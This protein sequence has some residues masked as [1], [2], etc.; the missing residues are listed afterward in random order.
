MKNVN[1]FFNFGGGVICSLIVMISLQVLFSFKLSAQ[2]PC[3]CDTPFTPDF[4]W[5][6]ESSS[7]VG[8]NFTGVNILISGTFLV[9]A[10]TTFSNCQIRL[11]ADADIS[12]SEGITLNVLS[13]HLWACT[14]TMWLGIISLNTQPIINTGTAINIFNSHIQDA[15]IAVLS[16]G[17]TKINIT[18]SLFENNLYGIQVQ[19]N[20]SPQPN[21]VVLANTF[22]S[23][24][25]VATHPGFPTGAQLINPWTNNPTINQRSYMGIYFKNNLANLQVGI[26]SPNTFNALEIG[27]GILASNVSV[28]NNV[29]KDIDLT[30]GANP[31]NET[32]AVLFDGWGFTPTTSVVNENNFT[33]CNRA[34][35][36]KTNN[37]NLNVSTNT[38]NASN[39]YL[40]NAS[41]DVWGIYVENNS[42]A[43]INIC[44]NTIENVGLAVGLILCSLSDVDVCSNRISNNSQA[45]NT[46]WGVL[47]INGI[48][49]TGFHEIQNN[50]LDNVQ[51]GIYA[52]SLNNPRIHN[53]EVFLHPLLV[54]NNPE[55]GMRT[56]ATLIP[57]IFNNMVS[58]TGTNQLLYA[59]DRITGIYNEGNDNALVFCNINNNCLWS[60]CGSMDNQTTP[61][62]GNALNNHRV[63]VAL[64]NG[65]V[66]GGQGSANFTNDN[67]WV[68]YC[69]NDTRTYGNSPIGGP[70]LTYGNLSPFMV[71]NIAPYN[72]I[73][74]TNELACFPITFSPTIPANPPLNENCTDIGVQ[75]NIGHGLVLIANGEKT[76]P[77]G[78]EAEHRHWDEV[79][80]YS[81]LYDNLDT[82]EK[83]AELD[84]FYAEI[85]KTPHGQLVAIERQLATALINNEQEKDS[86]PN[87]DGAWLSL[88]GDLATITPK[89]LQDEYQKTV[90]T[91][92]V[93]ANLGFKYSYTKQDADDITKIANTCPIRG[94]RTVYKA[95]AVYN[96]LFNLQ[97]IFDEN[98]D[99][100]I[101][102][103]YQTGKHQNQ[104]PQTPALTPPFFVKNDRVFLLGD[105]NGITFELYDLTGKSINTQQNGSTIS[106]QHLLNGLYLY[107]ILRNNSVIYTGKLLINNH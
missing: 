5:T 38:I 87:L 57:H 49:G 58:Y 78:W 7:N 98:C 14:N 19:L 45:N 86:L 83:Y 18:A 70:V 23:T 9:D 73:N 81:Y 66:I 47:D 67:T 82:L 31:L 77:E 35:L 60:F 96:T 61:L 17:N 42:N 84:S 8:T 46:F 2:Q 20:D 51:I 30:S 40:N 94:G 54:N 74:H 101:S 27:I 80:A 90:L 34:V 75:L 62:L 24:L 76:Y 11:C 99:A 71:R 79:Y 4:I 55:Y 93:N 10:N 44:N 102:E 50:S 72:P 65:G 97:L 103:A 69:P 100:E 53:N 64:R 36:S 39:L 16:F 95:R 107:K 43:T 105:G 56:D 89:T 21:F 85:A 3:T 106:L 6:N 68:P 48:T 91:L 15:E 104:T 33:D 26:S 59:D 29:F 13:S 41:L 22:A 63:G 1:S 92:L 88:L 52:A 28:G 37:L 12:V 25:V 32:A